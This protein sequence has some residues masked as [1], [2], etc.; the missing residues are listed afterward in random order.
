MGSLVGG[1]LDGLRGAYCE[2][3]NAQVDWYRNLTRL[4]DSPTLKDAS[5]WVTRT[6]CNRPPTEDDFPPPPFTGGQCPISYDVVVGV[7]DESRTRLHPD[8][9]DG[10]PRYGDWIPWEGDLF[11]T[12]VPGPIGGVVSINSEWHIDNPPKTPVNW[13]SEAWPNQEHV[14]RGHKA[15]IISVTPSNPSTPDD[16]G[17]PPF[18]P[19]PFEPTP[20][21]IDIDVTYGDN[22]QY[23]LV[24]PVIIAPVY[25]AFDGTLNAPVTFNISPDISLEGTWTLFPDAKLEINFP[26]APPGDPPGSRGDDEPTPDDPGDD[27]DGDP[28]GGS[29][30]DPDVP[31]KPDPDDPPEPDDRI[32]FLVCRAVVD[33]NARPTSLYQEIGP[34]LYVPRLGSARFG[35]TI[36]GVTFWT[37][38]IDIKGL[39]SI[40]EC[41]IPFGATRFTVNAAQGVAINY[42]PIYADPQKWPKYLQLGPTHTSDRR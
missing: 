42:S 15:W 5:N 38:D 41:P 25:V 33:S 13:R 34:D 30:D 29:E 24:V 4:V 17:D 40:I 39:N 10:T 31:G 11:F 32:H 22:N 20:I 28:D 3:L 23:S 1:L 26:T 18:D 12:G 8:N 6:V 9:P 21:N 16:C 35:A 19:G 36:D 14:N 27:P 2:V 37:P 7:S